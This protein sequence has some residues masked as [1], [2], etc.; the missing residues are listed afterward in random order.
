[1]QKFP[2]KIKLK[3][4]SK[5]G[6]VDLPS[7]LEACT[8]VSL[9]LCPKENLASHERSTFSSRRFQRQQRALGKKF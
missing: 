5:D 3:G 1:M 9:L 8:R 6:F 4:A 2:I 7:Q